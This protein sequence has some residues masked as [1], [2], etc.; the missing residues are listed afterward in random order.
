[1]L[2]NV[3]CGGIHD[4]SDVLLGDNVEALMPVREGEDEGLCVELFGEAVVIALLEEVSW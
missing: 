4:V 1:M 3:P 2:K